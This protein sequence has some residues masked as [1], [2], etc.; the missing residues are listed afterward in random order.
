MI[1]EHPP[2]L[3][4]H[5]GN[6]GGIFLNAFGPFHHLQ[7]HFLFERNATVIMKMTDDVET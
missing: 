7:A 6:E 2:F 3:L 5:H 1:K 4:P